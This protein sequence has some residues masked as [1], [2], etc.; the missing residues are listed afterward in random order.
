MNMGEKILMK[1]KKKKNALYFLDILRY[2]YSF[3]VSKYMS[4]L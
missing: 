3:G 4:V 2:R 1:S